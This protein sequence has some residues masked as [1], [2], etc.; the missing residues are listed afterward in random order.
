M[1]YIGAAGLQAAEEAGAEMASHSDWDKRTKRKVREEKQ[2]KCKVNARREILMYS[3]ISEAI[4]NRA[5]NIF[6]DEISKTENLF[7]VDLGDL[8][9]HSH[10]IDPA[11]PFEHWSV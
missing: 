6:E 2:G 3:C 7:L 5:A 1:P 8:I 10:D 4:I 11:N 9:K